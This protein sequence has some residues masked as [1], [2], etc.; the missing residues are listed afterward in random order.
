MN[1]EQ[2]CEY[3]RGI[4]WLSDYTLQPAEH[5][6][7]W[8]KGASAG[9]I[10]VVKFT[11]G[12]HAIDHVYD[13]QPNTLRKHPWLLVVNIVQ[14]S[15]L[16]T[17]ARKQFIADS[18]SVLAGADYT[19]IDSWRARYTN[20]IFTGAYFTINATL[21]RR[22]IRY[23]SQ[24]YSY[25]N[26]L[27]HCSYDVPLPGLPYDKPV[28]KSAKSACEKLA[29]TIAQYEKECPQLSE[30]LPI[31]MHGAN[32]I[33]AGVEINAD[34]PDFSHLRNIEVRLQKIRAIETLPQPIAEEIAPHLL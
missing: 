31:R 2:L 33:I 28:W 15:A 21:G 34:A 30:Q 4:H 11:F 16:K 20:V 19:V 23:D 25:A 6:I 9:T 7:R 26:L 14:P 3:L 12:G 13:L 32:M 27:S 5:R 8:S 24:R 29:R 18:I 22:H 1:P 10:Y 17:R